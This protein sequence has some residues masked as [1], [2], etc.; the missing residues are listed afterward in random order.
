MGPEPEPRGGGA[1]APVVDVAGRHL[2][3]PPLATPEL[4]AAEGANSALVWT[5]RQVGTRFPRLGGLIGF[6]AAVY[7]RFAR[8]RGSV[9]AGGLAFFGLLSL[10]PSLV[11]LGA[12]LATVVDPADAADELHAWLGNHT[13]VDQSLGPLLEQWSALSRTSASAI[14]VAGLVA[15]AFSLYAASRWVYVGRQVLD[16]AFEVTPRPPSFVA[17]GISV[18]VTLAFQLT[19]VVALLALSLVPRILELTGLQETLGAEIGLFRTPVT[20]LVVYLLLTGGLRYGLAGRPVRWVNLGALVGTLIIAVGSA[21][22]G[23][24]LTVS[25]TFSEIVAALGSVI[26]LQLWLYVVGIA[27]VMAAEIEALRL[28]YLQG[29]G[30]EAPVPAS[31]PLASDSLTFPSDPRE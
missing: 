17:R 14:G 2:A 25:V 16:I 3:R 27:I 13:K 31:G 7:G 6:G 9:L 11:S 5:A 30:T 21:G 18:A 22:L 1:S 15:L 19:L 10:V 4:A 28:G 29:R 24:Y 20:L 26:A 8:H 23:W 12:V